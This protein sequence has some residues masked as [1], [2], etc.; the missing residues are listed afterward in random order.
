M[1]ADVDQCRAQPSAPL[2]TFLPYLRSRSW[3]AA[4]AR[5]A[6]F[7]CGAFFQQLADNFAKVVQAGVEQND[8]T[9]FRQYGAG[10]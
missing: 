1:N 6:I 4:R 7:S 2:Q 8:A 10:H 5:S 9:H 3:L